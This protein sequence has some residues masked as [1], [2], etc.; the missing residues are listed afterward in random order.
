MRIGE[1][2]EQTSLSISNIR[3][4]EKKGLI[5]PTREQQSKYRDY[6]EEDLKQLKLIILYRK[7]DIPIESIYSLVKKESSL[8]L[9]IEQQIQDLL[10][11][12]ETIQGSIDLCQKVINNQA[13][14]QLDVDY[15]LNYVKSEEA[16]GTKFAQIDG[17]LTDFANFTQFD[18]IYGGV[19]FLKPWMNRLVML[20]WGMMWMSIPVSGIVDACL[21]GNCVSPEMIIFWMACLISFGITF[22]QFRKR[23]N[24]EEIL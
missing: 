21:N 12:Q 10:A 3:F 2:A 5:E 14:D 23:K 9:V 7:M 17:L 11:K 18:Q 1:I 15:Y 20:S 24:I 22:L 4:Y 8:E 6:T 19:I 16:N 13:F